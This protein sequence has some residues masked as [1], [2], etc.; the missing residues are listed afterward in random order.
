MSDVIAL[1][2]A[3]IHLTLTPPPARAGEPNWLRAQQR[4]LD[5][6]AGLAKEHNVPILFAGDVF[7]H[8]DAKPALINFAIDHLPPMYAIPGQHDLPL[9]NLAD[10]EKSAFWTLVKAKIITQVPLDGLTIGPIRVYGFPWGAQVSA[11]SILEKRSIKIALH[12]AYRWIK[13]CGYE[14]APEESRLGVGKEIPYEGFDIVITGD[15][16]IP[17]DLHY[18]KT[19]RYIFNCGSF[20]RRKSDERHQPRVGLI[21]DNG[22]VKAHY[23]DCSKESFVPTDKPET[24]TA[25]PHL[26]EFLKT[27][28][29]LSTATL[30]YG[31]LLR[32]A[33]DKIGADPAVRAI[34][35]GALEA[36]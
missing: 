5:E 21:R 19:K 4:S 18:E 22:T 16:H 13:N 31:D 25:Q 3:D 8:Y 35:E 23:L 34:L 12:H 7:D 6:L 20:Y 24:P 15:N 32:Q 33:A 10:I 2:V 11:P 28:R 36:K 26:A 17:F 1:A 9:H 14:G 29:D 30:D 27:V